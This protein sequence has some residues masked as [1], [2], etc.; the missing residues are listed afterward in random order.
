MIINVIQFP[1]VSQGKDAEFREWF[2]WSNAEMK[3]HGGFTRRRLLEPRQGGTYVVILEYESDE[4]LRALQA[5]PIN[6]EAGRRVKPLLEGDPVV[7]SY[8][9]VAG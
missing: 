5:S 6:E 2:A 4:F 7:T 3:K 1:P 9:V 8:R